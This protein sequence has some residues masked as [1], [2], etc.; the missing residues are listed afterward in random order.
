MGQKVSKIPITPFKGIRF[1]AITRAEIVYGNSRGYYLSISANKYR[2]WALFAIFDF[3][4]PNKG[5]CP[6]GT[7]TKNLTHLVDRLVH[8]FSL[9][10]VSNFFD[11]VPSP[12]NIT[13][14]IKFI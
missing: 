2:F 12:L 10:H 3:L 9:N 8:L 13:T 11:L 4:D 7:P 1:L 5:R 14:K 6:T